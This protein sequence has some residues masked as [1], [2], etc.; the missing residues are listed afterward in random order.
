[1]RKSEITIETREA[2]IVRF[3]P[4]APQRQQYCPYCAAQVVWL[5]PGDAA[6][7]TRQS[8]R[9][10]FGQLGQE[11]F[12]FQETPLGQVLLCLP[13][14]LQANGML[15]AG[16]GGEDGSAPTERCD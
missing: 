13:S 3:N 11:Q 15:V 10:I 6:R 12:H 5:S 1:M 8:L 4:R 14:L 16:G 9:Q 7:L 2:W